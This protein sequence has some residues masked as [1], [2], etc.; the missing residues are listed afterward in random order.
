[1]PEAALLSLS[2]LSSSRIQFAP[3]STPWR[4]TLLFSSSGKRD[5]LEGAGPSSVTMCGNHAQESGSI[6]SPFA[7][8]VT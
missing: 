3:H 6:L 5:L 1:M 4:W 2:E 8:G 7:W